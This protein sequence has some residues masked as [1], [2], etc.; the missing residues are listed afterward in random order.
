MLQ[1]R[2]NPFGEIIFT[3]ARGQWTGTRGLI[4][5][6]QQQITR[7]FRHKAWITCLLEFKGR[8]RTVMS[9]GLYTELFFLDEATAFAAGHRPCF[10]CRREDAAKFKSCWLQ[11][12][13]QYG[14]TAKTSVREIDNIIH[15]ERM[16]QFKPTMKQG[17]HIPD[18][19]FVAIEK[20]TY[21][22]IA[23]QF[24][25][26]SPFGYS[27]PVAIAKGASLTI[28]TPP[29][30]VNSFHSGYFPQIGNYKI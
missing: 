30:I 12:N 29:S 17:D 15:E 20:N 13:P 23:N 1:N 5:N 11:G 16:K 22:A 14:F 21:V 6:N 28:L 18:G 24:C 4:H 2:V 7:A 19:C 27:E 26:W 3:S 9:P 10:E 25:L 8:R